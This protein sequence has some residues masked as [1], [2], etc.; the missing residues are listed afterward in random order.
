MDAFTARIR[1]YTLGAKI[2]LKSHWA[3]RSELLGPLLTYGLF[4]T[5]FL[6]IWSAA[7]QGR[8]ELAGYSRFQV[9]WY[10]AFA[11]LMVFVAGGFFHGLS[12]EIK[13]G[14]IAYTLGRPYSFLGFQL[15]RNVG[16]TLSQILFLVP[17]GYLLCFLAVGPWAP[18]NL[19]HLGAVVLSAA[20]SLVL[21][22]FIQTSLSLTAFWVE[23]TIAFFWIY[24]KL[25]LVAG[26]LL[27]L[28][29]LPIGAQGILRWTPIP[30]LVWAPS[31]IFVH[32]EAS[33]ALG[34]LLSQ[35][36]WTLLAG[37]LAVVLFRV[38]VRRTLVQ[39]G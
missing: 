11:E 36:L 39:G 38:G 15:A 5:V 35:G 17:L 10:F 14:Q 37:V 3:Y 13:S 23:E 34:I 6:F 25:Y 24:Q 22:F 28:E 19:F 2:S 16:P 1:K 31:R 33:E 4:V 29:F 7:Y 21:Q 32:W 20:L 12:E 18:V 9:S 26:T 8:A 30:S 27:P